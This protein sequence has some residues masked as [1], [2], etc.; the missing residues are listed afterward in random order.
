MLEIGRKRTWKSEDMLHWSYRQIIRF[1]IY[2][3]IQI[4]WDIL[5]H[6]DAPNGPCWSLG[7]S[8][9]SSY[10]KRKFCFRKSFYFYISY[11]LICKCASVV[12]QIF[13]RAKIII[14]HTGIMHK[15][16]KK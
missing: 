10:K 11:T 6:L 3:L 9:L 8:T 4:L 15:F 7:A 14:D 1:S 13:I 2:N 12:I 5:K 16:V